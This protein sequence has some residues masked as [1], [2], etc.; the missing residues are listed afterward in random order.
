MK[1]N[2]LIVTNPPYEISGLYR[3]AEIACLCIDPSYSKDE[4]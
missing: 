3:T 1:N 4:N 2:D